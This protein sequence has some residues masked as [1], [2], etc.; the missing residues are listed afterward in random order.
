MCLNRK[1][2]KTIANG[3]GFVCALPHLLRYAVSRPV[4]GRERAFIGASE[5]LAK[6]PGSL[7][8]YTRQAFYR[9]AL[10]GVGGDVYFGF[11]SVFSKP[12][13][14]I[15]EGVYI[16]RF[17]CIGLANLGDGVMLA[18]GVQVLSGRHQHGKQSYEGKPLRDNAQEFA[19]VSIGQGAW[20]GA[21]SVVMADV[22]PRAVVG[23]GA[24]VVRPV[25]AEAKVGGVPA[26]PLK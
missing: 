7:G 24:V 1:C 15:G 4:L 25:A 5:R 13:A 22:G 3:L 14:V 26:K 19:E 10:G 20:L 8:V 6:I 17:C 11:M 16:G 12:N 9:R 23:A 2:Y 21:G 18:D